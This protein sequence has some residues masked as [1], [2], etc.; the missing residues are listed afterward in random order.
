MKD[1]TKNK[2]LVQ[3]SYGLVGEGIEDIYGAVI[4]TGELTPQR[5]KDL[6]DKAAKEINQLLTKYASR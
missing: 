1:K 5:I 3:L 4:D 2:S 6:S